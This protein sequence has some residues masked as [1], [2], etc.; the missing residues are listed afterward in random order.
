MTAKYPG[1]DLDYTLRAIPNV[2]FYAPWFIE[3]QPKS[4]PREIYDGLSDHARRLCRYIV[5]DI[6]T[7]LHTGYHRNYG[8]SPFDELPPT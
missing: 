7:S 8:W 4:V 3:P 6:G 1:P 5:T 2:E